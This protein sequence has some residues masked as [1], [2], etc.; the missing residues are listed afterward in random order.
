MCDKD[1]LITAKR[2]LV[3]AAQSP[4]AKVRDDLEEGLTLLETI[5]RVKPTILLGISGIGGLFT[6]EMIRE[7]SKH[8]ERP[9]IFPLSN[10]T[11]NS[12]ATAEQVCFSKKFLTSRSIDGLKVVLSLHQDRHLMKLE[13]MIEF[14]QQVK[15]ITCSSSLVLDWE[16]LFPKQNG[17][18]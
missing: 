9:I 15:E 7:M 2:K 18:Q 5:K 17:L 8:V 11:A 6:E 14:M 16:Q 1:G 10:P 12:E 13:S 4:F 3:T